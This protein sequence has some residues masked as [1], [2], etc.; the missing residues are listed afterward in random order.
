MTSGYRSAAPCTAC[1]RPC[2]AT[3]TCRTCGRIRNTCGE[4]VG[5]FSKPGRGECLHCHELAA[6]GAGWVD[7]WNHRTG[8]SAEQAE[9]LVQTARAHQGR[10]GA[11]EAT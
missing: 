4:R 9:L 5:G 8:R 11:K 10:R 1:S 6:F 2:A 3:F 7:G